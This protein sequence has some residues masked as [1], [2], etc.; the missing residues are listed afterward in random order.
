MKL[1]F[2]IALVACF[3]IGSNGHSQEIWTLK[4]CIETALQNNPGIAQAELAVGQ[5]MLNLKQSQY[6]RLPQLN[7]S[8]S[9]GINFGKN[10]DP[11]TNSFVNQD[12]TF[13]NYGLNY[14]I[15]LFNGGAVR[16]GIKRS[17]V[18][19]HAM[20]L[21]FEQ[22]S[23]DLALLVASQFLTVVRADERLAISAKNLENSKNQY[24]TVKKFIRVGTRP[25]LDGYELETQVARAEQSLIAAE[26]ALDLAWLQLKQSMR[27]PYEQEIE[28]EKVTIPEYGELLNTQFNYEAINS[29]AQTHQAAVRSA[30]LT[31]TSAHFSEKIAKAQFYPTLSLGGNVGSNYSSAFKEPSDFILKRTEVPGI[32]IDDKLVKFEQIGYSPTGY[33]L[34]PFG[35]QADLALNYGLGLSLQIPIWNQN[36]TRVNVQRA[37]LASRQAEIQLQQRKNELS[38]QIVTALANYKAS[39]KDYE[40]AKKTFD[41]AQTT[42][43]KVQKKMEIGTASTFELT[44][45]QNNAQSAEIGLVISKYD[46]LFTKKVLDFYSGKTQL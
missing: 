22:A 5:S 6:A 42:Y 40:A 9:G 14:G 3:F 21:T 19:L 45:A 25:E 38:Q 32:T 18:D 31:L 46:L 44:N 28:L 39:I 8:A 34:I 23:N 20:Q 16:N 15:L 10:I 41:A 35:K 7:A 24:E 43:L 12:V 33:K 4:K 11:S 30:E 29:Y 1:V 26:N 36:T 17:Q 2:N 37:K 13:G 27:V